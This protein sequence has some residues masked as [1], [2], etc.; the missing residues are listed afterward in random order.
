MINRRTL[1]QG[2]GATTVALATPGIVKAQSKRSLIVSWWGFNSDNL[3]KYLVKPFKE[4][5]GCD[6]VFDL[7][8]IADRFN[9]LR[10]RPGSVDIIYLSDIYVPPGIEAGLFESFDRS[11][12]PNIADIYPLAR[13]PQGEAWGPSYT[14][15]KYSIIY[16]PSKVSAPL[17]SWADL[18]RE[19]LKGRVAL[20]SIG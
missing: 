6:V 19:D 5:Y 7:G 16:D 17:T 13:A 8:P 9:R 12:I 3:D 11:K 18:W 4:K 1:L 2:V 20:P 14:V 15:Q 10:A